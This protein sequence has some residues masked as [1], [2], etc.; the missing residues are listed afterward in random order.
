MMVI[1]A[2]N[3]LRNRLDWSGCKANLTCSLILKLKEKTLN[4]YVTFCISIIFLLW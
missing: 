1:L 3:D 2:F 4:P